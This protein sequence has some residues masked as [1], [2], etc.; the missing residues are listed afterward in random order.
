MRN[1]RLQHI[2][3][4]TGFNDVEFRYLVV[5]GNFFESHLYP[6]DYEDKAIDAMVKKT[7]NTMDR[8]LLPDPFLAPKSVR[9]GGKPGI[10]ALYEWAFQ[11]WCE[12]KITVTGWLHCGAN[13]GEVIWPPPSA[14][15]ANIKA[16]R[17][18]YAPALPCPAACSEQ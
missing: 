17:S 6:S 3:S 16:I 13:W 9:S 14:Y 1:G 12:G 2:P 4:G 7:Y 15:K 5:M 11:Q 18:E 10:T 8:S